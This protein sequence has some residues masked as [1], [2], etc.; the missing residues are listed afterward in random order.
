MFIKIGFT[1]F[2]LSTTV[3]AQQFESFIEQ[4]LKKNLV[5]DVLAKIHDP[6]KAGIVPGTPMIGVLS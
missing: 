3:L 2:L 6:L 5:D 4:A 1:I